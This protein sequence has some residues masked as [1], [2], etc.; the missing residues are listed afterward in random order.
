MHK[1]IRH[2]LLTLAPAKSN[3]IWYPASFSEFLALCNEVVAFV[4]NERELGS[5][6]QLNI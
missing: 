5:Q 2:F 1:Y 4:I 6:L 3:Y